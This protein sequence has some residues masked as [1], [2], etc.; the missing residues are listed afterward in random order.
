MR[1]DSKRSF[2]LTEAVVAAF[3]ITITTVAFLAAFI[4]SFNHLKSTMELRN[5]SLILQE[6]VSIIR[7]LNFS[8]VQALGGSFSSSAMA[9]LQNAT[10]TIT[11]SN[12]QGQ[13]NIIKIT[14]TLNWKA[15]NGKTASRTVATLITDHGIDKK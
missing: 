1:I 15:F 9:S 11:K 5:A 10:G 13:A 12:Y 6:E 4:T 3:I 7:E 8:E 2:T 14:L